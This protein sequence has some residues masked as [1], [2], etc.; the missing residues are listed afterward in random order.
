[1]IFAGVLLGAGPPALHTALLMSFGVRLFPHSLLNLLFFI[2]VP[3]SVGYSI[4]KHNLFDVDVY[5]KR[6]VGYAIMT[7]VLAAT[8]FF[9]QTVLSKLI[10]EPLFAENAQQVYP[11]VFALLVV[12]LFNPLNTRVQGAVDKL[13]YRKQFDYKDTVLSIG[14][15]LSTMLNSQDIMARIIETL[16]QEMFIDKVGIVLMEKGKGGCSPFFVGNEEAEGVQESP[17]NVCILSSDPL[18]S[19]MNRERRLITRFDIEEST[20]FRSIRESVSKSFDEFG[21]TLSIPLLHQDELIGVLFIGQKKSGKFFVREDIELLQ[22]LSQQGA[23]ALENAR[24]AE[25]MQK[26]EEVRSN[27]ARYLSP[28]IVDNMM[29]DGVELNLGGQRKTVTILFSDIRN[30]TGISETWPPDQLVTILNEYMTEMVSI[31]FKHKGSIDKYVGDAIIAVFGSLI[32]VENP[33]ENAAR[34]AIEMQ[35]AMPALNE[36]WEKEYGVDMNMGVGVTTGD[37]FLGNIGSPERMEF[38]VIGDAVNV[39]S[40]FSGVAKGKEII[41]DR[42]STE[43]LG[44]E[45]SITEMP[46]VKVKGKADEMAIFRIEY[47]VL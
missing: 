25:Q 38:T 32:D 20:H 9:I 10:L 11:I 42:A 37:V 27:L 36:R 43:K 19:L 46:K 7:V 16:R 31:V 41:V 14:A 2:V 22:M 12:T 47:D 45:F 5:I 21:A 23:V 39:A 34:A 18:I 26:E 40:R 15:A 6:T 17:D 24:L 8:Y 28:Q 44:E 3:I 30:F 1:M 13:F 35:Q 33:A 29:K 4:V